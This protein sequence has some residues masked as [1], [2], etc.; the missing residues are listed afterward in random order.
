[1]QE[2]RVFCGFLFTGGRCAVAARTRRTQPD[3]TSLKLRTTDAREPARA[4]CAVTNLP[5]AISPSLEKFAA[6]SRKVGHAS[7]V[8][9]VHRNATAPS[10][11]DGA[12]A[13][14][15]PPRSLRRARR[16]VS[17]PGTRSPPRT[18][19]P[20]GN[21]VEAETGPSECDFATRGEIRKFRG[22]NRSQR[23]FKRSSEIFFAGCGKSNAARRL[24]SCNAGIDL[25]IGKI[26][27]ANRLRQRIRETGR[28]DQRQ[29]VRDDAKA[30]AERERA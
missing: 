29:P 5:R 15:H 12:R 30:K 17:F 25:A 16:S 22:R 13:R 14:L 23:L 4:A 21:A 28:R 2:T 3:T 7:L 11:V 24:R 20:R 27:A 6:A 19:T 10:L 8:D 1:M 9:S 26:V 18:A